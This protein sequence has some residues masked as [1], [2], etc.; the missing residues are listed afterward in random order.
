MRR[1]RCQCLCF[2]MKQRLDMK[3]EE[4]KNSSLREK[5]REEER[6]E[7]RRGKSTDKKREKKA[8][9]GEREGKQWKTLMIASFIKNRKRAEGKNSSGKGCWGVFVASLALAFTDGVRPQLA[10]A[11]LCLSFWWTVACAPLPPLWQSLPSLLPSFLSPRLLLRS[12]KWLILRLLPQTEYTWMYVLELCF[13]IFITSH[14]F[15]S[16]DF[17]PRDSFL[18]LSLS[19]SLLVFSSLLHRYPPV[20]KVQML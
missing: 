2:E 8:R 18:S 4:T 9:R 13:V 14:L 15:A 19:P 16:P 17:Y 20:I 7:E 11:L 1:E 6:A 10:F 3:K 12:H 5:R